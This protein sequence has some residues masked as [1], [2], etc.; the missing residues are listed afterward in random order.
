MPVTLLGFSPSE[1]S[2]PSR[3]V[4]SLDARNL[5]DVGDSHPMRS[6]CTRKPSSAER[7]KAGEQGS[8]ISAFFA[9]TRLQGLAPDRS[10]LHRERGLDAPEPDALLGFDPLQGLRRS[11]WDRM[12]P[13]A[14][15]PWTS[16]LLPFGLPE[17]PDSHQR[18]P[19][20]V[21]LRPMAAARLSSE[22][23]PS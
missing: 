8:R 23:R 18:W 22:Q 1:P 9:A 3:A 21:L 12:L 5:H 14:L 11:T 15:L 7:W 6:S 16:P 19:F 13:P 17:N 10:P 4:A 20:G 2:P